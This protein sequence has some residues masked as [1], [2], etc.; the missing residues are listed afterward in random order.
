MPIVRRASV[1]VRSGGSGGGVTQNTTLTAAGG[2]ITV[3]TTTTGTNGTS[4]SSNT[5]VVP[6]QTAQQ[7]AIDEITTAF[8]GFANAVN[9]KGESLAASDLL[10]EVISMLI[11][12]RTSLTV[13]PLQQNIK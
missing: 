2:S 3:V 4:T 13:I 6:V 12:F 7:M 1:Q 9:T 5:T 11:Q 8:N 10:N